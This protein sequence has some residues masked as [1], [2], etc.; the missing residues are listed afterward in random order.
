MAA[1]A[2]LTLV[3][4]SGWVLRHYYF[5]PAYA[6]PDWRQVAHT[7]QGFELQGD[8]VIITGDGGEKAFD[9]YY[10]GDLPVYIDFNSP[11]PPENQARLSG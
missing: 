11:V 3:F 8:A 7:I 5:D 6:R 1:L 2:L 4:I 9:I 10:Q